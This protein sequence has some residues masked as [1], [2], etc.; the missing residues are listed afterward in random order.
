MDYNR[1]VKNPI[2]EFNWWLRNMST[3]MRPDTMERITTPE[4][5]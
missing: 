1:Y 5:A 4:L 3:V 2:F